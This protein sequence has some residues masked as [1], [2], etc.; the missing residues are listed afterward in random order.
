MSFS[1]FTILDVVGI[2][3]V[4]MI[5]LFLFRPQDASAPAKPAVAGMEAAGVVLLVIGAL[6]AG[7]FFLFYDTRA[8]GTDVANLSRL[9]DRQ[10][11][12]MIGMGM[13]ILGG[14][15][16]GIGKRN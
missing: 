6:L 5:L 13:A 15:L 8:P 10:N 16:L 1:N 4:G 3:V 2:A 14:I 12:V 9:S 7:Y 11:G